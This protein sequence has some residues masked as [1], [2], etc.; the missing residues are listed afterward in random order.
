MYGSCLCN[1]YIKALDAFIGFTK[2]D[3][4]E[5]RVNVNEICDSL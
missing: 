4:L 3:M 1:E 2:K 5:C